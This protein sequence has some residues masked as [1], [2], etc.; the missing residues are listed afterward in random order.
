MSSIID[1]KNKINF[2][3]DK[4]EAAGLHC[5]G[6]HR[7]R[8]ERVDLVFL[9]EGKERVYLSSVR[10]FSFAILSILVLLIPVRRD[11]CRMETAAFRASRISFL[12]LLFRQSTDLLNMRTPAHSADYLNSFFIRHSFVNRVI[13]MIFRTWPFKEFPKCLSFQRGVSL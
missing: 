11:N 2:K 13:Q 8:W 10:F 4:K 1:K 9:A 5:R 12:L 7:F 3:T 6:C